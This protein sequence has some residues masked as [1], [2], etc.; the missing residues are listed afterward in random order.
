MTIDDCY[1]LGKV[2]KKHGFKGNLI[3]HLDTDEPELYNT[4]ESVFIEIDG[5][6]IPF[7]FETAQPYQGTKL[8]VKFEDLSPEEAER[9]VNRPIY[10]PLTTLPDLT[11]NAF[12][13][14]EVI[15]FTIYDAENIEVGTITSI[16]DSAAQAY[17]E[18]NAEGKNILIPMIDQFIIEVDRSNK[19]ILM[20]MPDGLLD[21]YLK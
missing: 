3:I 9:L 13:Y 7:F 8:L 20:A 18:V 17:F 19:A 16:N 15:G 10:L 6:L 11:G 5:S 2:T 4:L 1:Y 12:Y 14:H 21:V